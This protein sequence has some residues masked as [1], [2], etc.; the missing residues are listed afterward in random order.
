MNVW[1]QTND[2]DDDPF[3]GDF[4][5]LTEIL[6]GIIISRF[7]LDQIRKWLE[8]SKK[9]TKVIFVDPYESGLIHGFTL[10]ESSAEPAPQM[11]LSEPPLN[12]LRSDYVYLA[13]PGHSFM[14]EREKKC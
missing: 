1:Y 14:K 12:L 11:D 10:H 9:G 2:K 6:Q 8:K 13:G 3:L 7:N 4:T 5:D